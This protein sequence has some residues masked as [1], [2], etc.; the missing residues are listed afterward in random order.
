MDE[1]LQKSLEVIKEYLGEDHPKVLEAEEMF[2]ELGKYQ[3]RYWNDIVKQNSVDG[4][5]KRKWWQSKK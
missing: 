5:P 3:K 1:D 4:I 2:T